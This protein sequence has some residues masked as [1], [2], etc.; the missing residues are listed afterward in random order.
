[1]T[2]C[3]LREDVPNPSVEL[4]YCGRCGVTTHWT[5]TLASG[6]DRM[7][8]NMRLFAPE[9]LAGMRA[10]YIDGA[11]WDGTSPPEHLRSS[12]VIGEDAFIS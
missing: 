8:V 6:R 9:E 1:M 5:A 2:Q 11:G 12:G 4:H 7:G 10:Q 3:Y